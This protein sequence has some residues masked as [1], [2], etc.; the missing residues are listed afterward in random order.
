MTA[1]AVRF[2]IGARTL[3]SV[4]RR[5][6][7][8]ALSLDDVR[9]GVVPPRGALAAEEDGFLLTSLPVAALPAI[10]TDG[11]IA[12]VRQRYDRSWIDL[13]AG[14]AAWRAGLSANA[15]A[16]LRRKAR[17]LGVHEVRRYRTPDEIAAFHAAARALSVSTY[18]ERLLDEGLPADAAPLLRLAAADGARA[19]LLRVDDTPVA[20]L[21]CTADRDTLRYEHV[22]Y[23]PAWSQLSPGA[24]LQGEALGDLFADRFARFDFTEGDGQHKRR[25]ATNSVPCVDL[26]L[27]RATAANRALVAAL[28]AWDALVAMAKRR[29]PGLKRFRR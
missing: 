18:Q 19:W 8:I 21:C 23:D 17:R 3:L 13:T 6:R 22:G 10:K 1:A 11:L 28:R 14:E 24:V 26:L 4:S 9:A 5:L 15:R 7:R 27:L 12:F 2:G 16:Q 20:Y 29:T 25:F